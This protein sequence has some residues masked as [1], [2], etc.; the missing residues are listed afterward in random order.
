ME[1]K[2]SKFFFTQDSIPKNKLR[3]KEKNWVTSE[4]N[5]NPR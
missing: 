3:P 1:D 5:P 2:N 4:I